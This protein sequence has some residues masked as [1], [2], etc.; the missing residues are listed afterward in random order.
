MQPENDN[1]PNTQPPVEPT[2]T[3][4]TQQPV[5]Q[6]QPQ[7]APVYG[8]N[9]TA[10]VN[11]DASKKK[12]RTLFAGIAIALVVILGGSAGAYFGIVVPNKPENI[13]KN[14]LNN[15][16]EA[17]DRIVSSA[18]KREEKKGGTVKGNFK[19]DSKDIAFDGNIDAKYYEKNADIKVDAGSS[20]V[21]F[22][23]AALT[24]VPDG[25][26]N[27][28]VYLK[29]TG[30]KGI[31]TLLGDS[32]AGVGTA[33]ASYDNQ[34][35][36]VDHTLLDELEKNAAKSQSQSS[37]PSFSK[38]DLNALYTAIGKVNREYI[39]TT[40]QSKAVL[41]NT[42]N[43]GKEKFDD[44]DAYHFKVAY[45]KDNLKAYTNAMYGELKNTKL[46]DVIT[47][48]SL[49][50]TL[51][52]IDKLDG[53]QQAD[54][55]VDMDTKLIRNV[56]IPVDESGSTLDI[57][58]KY[59]GGDE[60]PYS[61]ALNSK[62][63]GE[64]GTFN[65]LVTTRNNSDDITFKLDG[66]GVDGNDKVTFGMNATLSPNN[67]KVNVQKPEGAKSL[68]EAYSQLLGTNSDTLI[69]ELNAPAAT[70]QEL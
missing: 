27:P 46:K 29:V 34:W 39:F 42:E 68:L 26:K 16:A 38:D 64:E 40:D 20:G 41:K 30:L 31:D 70:T 61:I 7:P 23:L 55:W 52:S 10:T 43:I 50:Q 58:Q 67:D 3:N 21:R 37:I 12:K 47:E 28:D 22:N 11:N 57:G 65:I 32:A 63:K 5:T 19:L 56:R 44:R 4:D 1:Q 60:V 14:G 49:K 6:N 17:Y 69:K 53:K 45:N 62:E 18:Q 2:P 48:D 33:L 66:N 9:Q 54:A 24:T 35:Y 8:Q 51:A 36:V 15:T 59:N 13:W 25:A